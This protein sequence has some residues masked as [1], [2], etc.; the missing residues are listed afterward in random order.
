MAIIHFRDCVTSLRHL[1]RL[2]ICL[3]GS[4]LT[5]FILAFLSCVILI[6]SRNIM[7]YDLSGLLVQFFAT[8]GGL[9]VVRPPMYV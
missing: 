2:T 1:Y 5:I 8:N 3:Q 9:T 6:F 7:G 4:L